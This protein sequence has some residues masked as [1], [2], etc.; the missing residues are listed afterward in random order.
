MKRSIEVKAAHKRF[1]VKTDGSVLSVHSDG[2]ELWRS[3]AVEAVSDLGKEEV[4]ECCSEGEPDP[5]PKKR[6]RKKRALTG[7]TST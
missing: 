7:S 6:S 4:S 2:V 5:K 1:E 3:D